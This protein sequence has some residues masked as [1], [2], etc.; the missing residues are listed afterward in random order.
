MS[1]ATVEATNGGK[2]FDVVLWDG[3]YEVARL[4]A[5]SERVAYNIS[6]SI[7]GGIN[8]IAFDSS[9]IE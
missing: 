1:I 9:R 5:T 8:T 4:S 6:D 3:A 7:N 2:A